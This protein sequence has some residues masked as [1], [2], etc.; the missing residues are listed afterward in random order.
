MIKSSGNVFKDMGFSDAE[1]ASLLIR[2]DLAL[3]IRE[4]LRKHKM[5][6]AAAAEKLG[7][8]QPDVSA[9]VTG[10]IEKFSIDYLIRQLVKLGHVVKMKSNNRRRTFSV[11]EP[12]IRIN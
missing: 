3:A 9:I 8:K 11:I 10:K 1:A 2:A 12:H 6:Q 7:I 5:S 4:Y